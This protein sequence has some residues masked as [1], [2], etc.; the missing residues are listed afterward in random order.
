[1]AID[2]NVNASFY[3]IGGIGPHST[4]TDAYFQYVTADELWID[5]EVY[6]NKINVKNNALVKGVL[7]TSNIYLGTFPS[8]D[9]NDSTFNL[10]YELRAKITS[11][12]ARLTTLEGQVS[13]LQSQ[14]TFLQSDLSSHSH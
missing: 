6:A 9:I 12:E 3:D 10:D 5:N 7:K 1:M 11:I 13:T 14:V 4:S 2:G 8:Q